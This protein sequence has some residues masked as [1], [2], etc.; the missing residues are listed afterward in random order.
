MGYLCFQFGPASCEDY[1]RLYR[2]LKM[3]GHDVSISP[4]TGGDCKN[5]D[6]RRVFIDR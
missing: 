2:I 6:V 3:S 1:K 5:A 4:R